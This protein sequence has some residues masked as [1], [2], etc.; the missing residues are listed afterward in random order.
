MTPASFWRRVDRSGECWIWRST[1]D[2]HGYGKTTNSKATIR[3]HR[4]SW[5]LEHGP[6]PDGSYVLHRCDNRLCVRPGHLYLGTHADNMRDMRTRG[7]A[8]RLGRRKVSAEQ[9]LE[10]RMRGA[11]GAASLAREFGL[12]RVNTQKIIKGKTWKSLAAAKE[13]AL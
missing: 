9:A 7:R 8:A 1:V 3:A 12:S 11:E 4:L 5:L 6:I 13:G 10:I 2:S